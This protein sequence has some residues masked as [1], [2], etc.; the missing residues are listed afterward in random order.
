MAF[1]S[2]GCRDESNAEVEPPYLPEFDTPEGITDAFRRAFIKNDL[3]LMNQVCVPEDRD[4][5][6]NYVAKLN[7]KAKTGGAV[8]DTKYVGDAGST[9][10]GNTCWIRMQFEFARP[11]GQ[12]S[13]IDEDP[14]V[15]AFSRNKEGIWKYSRALSATVVELME[16]TKK[17]ESE[18]SEA[19]NSPDDSGA[20]NSSEGAPAAE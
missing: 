12:R 1:V 6:R 14:V 11:N 13:P 5:M 2:F 4:Y 16:E 20:G 8:I 18:D 7:D 17:K 3:E 10:D 15:I 9:P 19:G